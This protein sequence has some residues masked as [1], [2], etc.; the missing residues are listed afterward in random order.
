MRPNFK[1]FRFLLA[2]FFPNCHSLTETYGALNRDNKGRTVRRR[3][4]MNN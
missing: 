1:M 3:E 2:A 4:R